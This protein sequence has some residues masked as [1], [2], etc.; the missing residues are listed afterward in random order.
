M[1]LSIIVPLLVEALF[2]VNELILLIVSCAP[3]LIVNFPTCN[4]LKDRIK[5]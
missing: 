4:P 1:P 2:I 3:A 5:L